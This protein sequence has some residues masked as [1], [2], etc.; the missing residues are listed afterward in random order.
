MKS[1]SPKSEEDHSPIVKNEIPEELEENEEK[2][3]LFSDSED[4]LED[5]IAPK[6]EILFV[7]KPKKKNKNYIEKIENINIVCG[8]NKN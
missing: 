4:D 1:K 3:Y 8:K 5:K 7:M 6:K 2:I